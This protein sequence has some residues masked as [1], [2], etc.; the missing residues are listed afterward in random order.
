M[1]WVILYLLFLTILNY[2]FCKSFFSFI[3]LVN[4]N[5]LAGICVDRELHG[6]LLHMSPDLFHKITQY[7]ENYKDTSTEKNAITSNLERL[8]EEE[9]PEIEL[10]E[11]P[12]ALGDMVEAILG[13][14]YLDSKCDLKQTW[15]VVKK[16]YGQTLSDFLEKPQ[17]SFLAQLHEKFPEKIK[18]EMAEVHKDGK[19]AVVVKI[20][21]R[22]EFK[23][24][25][26]NKKMAKLAA[27]KCALRKTKKD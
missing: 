24:I 19:V 15:S 10:V 21:E 27:A 5:T 11:I 7:Y 25:G 17:K 22:K 18:F 20:D 26:A 9:V 14:V 16:I 3:H 6:H 4:N 1:L 12:K 8:N 13:A 2:Y 23:G